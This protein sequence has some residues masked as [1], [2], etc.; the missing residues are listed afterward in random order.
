VDVNG[1]RFHL[2][3]GEDGWRRCREDGQTQDGAFVRLHLDADSQA[4]TLDPQLVLFVSARGRTPL[5]IGA[6]RGAAVDRFGNWYWI[7]NDRRQIFWR[8]EG[9][10][11]SQVFWSQARAGVPAPSDEFAP[12][13]A[14]E[15]AEAELGGLAVT[16][17]HYLVVGDLTGRGLFVFDLHAGGPP[18]H[19][20]FPRGLDFKPFDMAAAPRGGVWVL[21]RAHRAYWGLDRNF[22]VLS[23]GA[24][25]QEIAP[26][27]QE[28]FHVEGGTATIH[29]ARRFPRGFELLAE[30]EDPVAIEAL[31]DGSVLILDSPAYL[32]TGLDPAPPSRVHHYR[33]AAR[34]DPPITLAGQVHTVDELTQAAMTELALVGYDFAF[35]A[36]DEGGR[37]GTAYVVER[38]GN[39]TVAFGLDFDAS[40]QAAE[41][42]RDFLPMHFFGSRALVAQGAELYYDVL[43]GDTSNDRAV[44]WT[45]LRSIDE[46]RYETTGTLQ[47]YDLDGKERDCVWHRLFLDACIPSESKVEVWTR[48][49]NDKS[50]LEGVEWQLEPGPYLRGEGAEVP[51]YNPF[52]QYDPGEIPENTGTWELLFQQARGR[53]LQLRLVLTGNGRTTPRLYALRAYY[54]RF[55]YPKNYL[56]GAYLADAGSFSFLERLLANEEG[57]YSEIE[58]KVG[59]VSVLFDARSAPPETLD[60]LAGWVGV[61]LD[62][63]WADI[64]KQREE[65]VRG[66]L[67]ARRRPFD[68][69]RLFIR[70]AR[71]L[72]ERRG[73]PAGIRFALLLLLDPC[74]EVTLYRLKR[75]AVRPQQFAAFVEELGRYGL[76]ERYGQPERD[77]QRRRLSTSLSEEEFEDLLYDYVLSPQRPSKVRVVERY[78]TRGGRRLQE[79]DASVQSAGAAAPEGRDAFAHQFSVLVPE[80]LT[81]EEES[82]AGRIAELEKPAHTQFDVRRYWDFFRVGETRLGIDTVLG[83]ESR[84]V[85]MIIGRT[86][87]A[88]GYLRPSHPMDVAERVVSDR[89]SLGDGRSL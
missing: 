26:G 15:T 68:R 67:P 78:R 42:R 81:P 17:H 33:L 47:T 37:R 38:E 40:P 64:Q 3:K 6:R 63:L 69:R 29:P 70:F 79:G 84:F 65:H 55:S 21:D 8:P 58:G 34:L 72:Y 66:Q 51:F 44:R 27:E 56:P 28:V 52:P 48:A 71:K 57:F 25:M 11:K 49:H 24:Q 19:M 39:Q 35:V 60:W 75:A 85:E 32:S 10:K 20:L 12:V 88:E 80:A 14:P 74:L 1:T 2:I 86:Y 89:D 36:E 61:A 4:L 59:D 83:E 76:L 22:C 13:A 31:P 50:L 46:S 45:P 9:S 87:L 16:T 77:G 82:M 41:V 30:V 18:M 23:E 53:Y 7:G 5:D 73:T 62:P 43:G 54:P